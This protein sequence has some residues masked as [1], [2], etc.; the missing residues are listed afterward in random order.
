MALHFTHLFCVVIYI[1]YYV[2]YILHIYS[3]YLLFFYYV[4]YILHICS[5]YLYIMI[6]NNNSKIMLYVCLQ[7]NI[8]VQSIG[9]WYY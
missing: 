2:F 4:F 1:F 5:G 6:K 8:R 7:Y 9:N 3:V